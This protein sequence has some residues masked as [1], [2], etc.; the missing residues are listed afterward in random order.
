MS[1]QPRARRTAQKSSSRTPL[2]IG[3]AIVALVAIALILALTI[4]GEKSKFGGVAEAEALF[5]GVPQSGFTVGQAD[6]PVTISEFADIQC[7]YC[8]LASTEIV[9]AIVNDFVK[10]GDAKLEFRPLEFLGGDSSKAAKAAFA[11]G[12]Q[13]KLWQMVEVLYHSQGGENTGW[14]TD[15]L[16]T[17]AA[18][19]LGLDVAKFHTDRDS[20]DIAKLLADSVAEGAAKA[21]RSTPTFVVTGPK[22]SVVVKNATADSFDSAIAQVR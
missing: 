16:L 6:A 2:M 14:V 11:A 7:P 20:P 22:G 17:K 12:Q 1:Q 18:T 9:P 10:P 3:A 8:K 21:I 13:G 5:K 19:D 15:E 4:G